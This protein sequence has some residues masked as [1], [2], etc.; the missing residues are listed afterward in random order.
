MLLY[1]CTAACMQLVRTCPHTT[2][3]VYLMTTTG[4]LLAVSCECDDG[5]CSCQKTL[6]IAILG[7]SGA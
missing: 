7:S 5:C 4:P 6:C 1:S 2:L 3:E